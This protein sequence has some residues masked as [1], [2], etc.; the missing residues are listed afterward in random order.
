LLREHLSTNGVKL[1]QSAAARIDGKTYIKFEVD[2]GNNLLEV[3][4]LLS[5]YKKICE[6]ISR[7]G[8]I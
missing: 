4:K 1:L 7:H 2:H 5:D 8:I 6:G 3:E